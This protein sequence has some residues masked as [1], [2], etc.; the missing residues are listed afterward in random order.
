[1]RIKQLLERIDIHNELNPALWDGNELNADVRTAM[2][3]IAKA[4]IDHVG[5]DITVDD[6]TLTGS[7]A[8]YTWNDFSDCDLHV[9][10][11]GVASEEERELYSAKKDLWTANRDIR[12]RGIPVE[13]YVQ[14]ADE[15]HH[16]TGVYSVLKDEW[17]NRP[18]KIRPRIN[19]A[20]IEAKMDDAVRTIR[21]AVLSRDL[22]TINSVKSRLRDMRS[23]G[24][25]RAGEWSTEN[26]VFKRLRN[27]GMI[28][29]LAELAREL[30]DRELSLENWLDS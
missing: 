10:V 26:Q 20:A 29:R 8:N 30:E 27:L 2:L 21:R 4:F 11:P 12:V 13:C 14:G 17:I 25:E 28:D 22:D 15:P 16:S 24:L 9:I 23:A 3:K 1:M 19:D 18:R 7:N 6:I 5:V